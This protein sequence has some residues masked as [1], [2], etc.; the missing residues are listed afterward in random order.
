MP[1]TKCTCPSD[2]DCCVCGYEKPPKKLRGIRQTEVPVYCHNCP[3]DG[4]LVRLVLKPT[5]SGGSREHFCQRCARLTGAGY[6]G[7]GGYSAEKAKKKL[8]KVKRRAKNVVDRATSS[9]KELEG[10]D[11]N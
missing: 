8:L 10:N 6:Y 7:R 5:H 11:D 3:D 4:A 9:I 2:Y 1:K